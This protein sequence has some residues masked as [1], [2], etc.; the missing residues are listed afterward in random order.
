MPY[1]VYGEPDV[2]TIYILVK[3]SA[4][5]VTYGSRLNVKWGY[6]EYKDS[7]TIRKTNTGLAATINAYGPW[8]KI[9]IENTFLKYNKSLSNFTTAE[10]QTYFA[11]NGYIMDI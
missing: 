9:N 10:N 6:G 4:P 11:S 7:R 5:Q 2:N 3:V 1:E 8:M